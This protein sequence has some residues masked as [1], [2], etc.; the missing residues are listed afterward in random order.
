MLIYLDP[1]LIEYFNKNNPKNSDIESLENIITSHRNGYHYVTSNK[2]CLEFISEMDGLSEL[3]KR[4]LKMLSFDLSTHSTIGNMVETKIVVKPPNS[5]FNR[6]DKCETINLQF[7]NNFE[8]VTSVFEI[9]LHQFLITEILDK[10]RLI[11]EHLDDCY[12]YEFISGL[13][14]KINNLPCKVTFDRVHGGGNDTHTIYSDKLLENYIVV[15]VVDSDKKDPTCQLGNTSKQVASVYNSKK[16]NSLIGYEL[17]PFHEKENLFS[18]TIYEYFGKNIRDYSLKQLRIL[19][20]CSLGKEI[21][22]Y[23]DIKN[24]LHSSNFLPFYEKVFELP[25]LILDSSVSEK[26]EKQFLGSKEKFLEYYSEQKT[27]RKAERINKYLI[28]PLGSNPLGNF[29]IS[30]IIREIE[31]E[32]DSLHPNTPDSVFEKKEKKLEIAKNILP[33]LMDFQREYF[34]ILA[35]NICEWGISNRKKSC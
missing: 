30:K 17:L 29:N 21:Y 35:K 13:Y 33:H 26:F 2:E 27:K 14:L 20:E 19:S 16:H 1:L 18:P 34:I 11:S 32:L 31:E 8:R 7:L 5:T 4:Q 25:G 24:G 6:I 22:P 23:I 3:N 10:T 9:P 28:E 12:L 15:A